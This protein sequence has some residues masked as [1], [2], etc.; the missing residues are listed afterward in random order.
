MHQKLPVQV[1]G[2]PWIQEPSVITLDFRNQARML[3]KS[4]DSCTYRNFVDQSEDPLILYKRQN[5]LLKSENVR[6]KAENAK[7]GAELTKTQKELESLR[8]SSK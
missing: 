8:L 5:T 2:E 7:L 6:L 1:D 3:Y 4:N